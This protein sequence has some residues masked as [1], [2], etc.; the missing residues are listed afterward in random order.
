MIVDYYPETVLL[1]QT[2]HLAQLCGIIASKYA[3]IRWGGANRLKSD[4]DGVVS[5]LVQCLHLGLDITQRLTQPNTTPADQYRYRTARR[6]RSHIQMVTDCNCL[7]GA[8][9]N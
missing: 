2:D 3:T 1:R 5:R 9:W 4:P 6:S 8:I 7:P